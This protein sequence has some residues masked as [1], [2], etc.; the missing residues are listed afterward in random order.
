MPDP[1]AAIKLRLR[2]V[3]RFRVY[4]DRGWRLSVYLTHWFYFSNRSYPT[5]RRYF[6]RIGQ[7]RKNFGPVRHA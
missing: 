2:Q 4:L 7:W 3:T 5:E 6:V 1:A